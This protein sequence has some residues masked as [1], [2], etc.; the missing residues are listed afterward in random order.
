MIFSLIPKQLKKK[1]GLFCFTEHYSFHFLLLYPSWYPCFPFHKALWSH[2]RFL[3]TNN[4]PSFCDTPSHPPA[5]L[6]KSHKET[7][8]SN[9]KENSVT[10]QHP[11]F[12]NS[13]TITFDVSNKQPP[14]NP[15]PVFWFIWA[16]RETCTLITT[17][18]E[19]TA[20]EPQTDNQVFLA[21]QQSVN[22]Y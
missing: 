12:L 22:P 5:H 16:T 8:K 21:F 18:L 17:K 6:K 14:E 2:E 11:F 3:I 13:L 7:H 4:A 10:F 1:Q 9:K 20:N 19:E 15:D